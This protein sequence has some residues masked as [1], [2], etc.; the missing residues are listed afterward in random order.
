MATA[1]VNHVVDI[2]RTFSRQRGMPSARCSAGGLI[3]GLLLGYGLAPKFQ[4]V[5]EP[6]IPDGSTSVPEGA[7]MCQSCIRDAGLDLWYGLFPEP[8]CWRLD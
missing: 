5:R 6:V 1:F 2:S 8:S 3:A 7:L 4:V